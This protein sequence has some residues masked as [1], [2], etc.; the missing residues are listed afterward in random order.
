[1]GLIG[2]LS[3]CPVAIYQMTRFVTS[4]DPKDLA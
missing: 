3:L 1:M 2:D 4:C